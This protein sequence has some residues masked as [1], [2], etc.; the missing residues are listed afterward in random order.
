MVRFWAGYSAVSPPSLTSGLRSRDS[1]RNPITGGNKMQY[2]QGDVFIEEVASIPEGA[3]RVPAL[4]GRYVIAEGE[5]TGHAHTIDE[6]YGE[7]YEH[8]GVLY[9]KPSAEA[10][11]VH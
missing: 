10:T 7:L 9:F 11:L 8:K 2:R 4:N 1:A 6:K 3:R 5:A